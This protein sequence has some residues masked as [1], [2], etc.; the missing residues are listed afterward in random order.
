MAGSSTEDVAWTL[1]QIA[2]NKVAFDAMMA[3]DRKRV[4]AAVVAVLSEDWVRL[5]EMGYAAVVM[6]GALR[7]MAGD[8]ADL[9][10]RVVV[11]MARA[12]AALGTALMGEAGHG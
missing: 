6:L 9:Y 10:E 5:D 4:E 3:V 11:T 1:E 2:E 7:M 8:R 12:A